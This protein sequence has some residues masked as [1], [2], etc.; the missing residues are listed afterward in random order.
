MVFMKMCSF[1]LFVCLFVCL[2]FCHFVFGTLLVLC[3]LL[4]AVDFCGMVNAAGFTCGWLPKLKV[5]RF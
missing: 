1:P 5:V 3:G 2:C 4:K